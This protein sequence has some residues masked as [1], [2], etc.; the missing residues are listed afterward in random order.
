MPLTTHNAM[1]E[2]IV[3][4]N[5]PQP[6]VD[7]ERLYQALSSFAGRVAKDCSD[8]GVKEAAHNFQKALRDS[9]IR[10]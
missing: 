2:N 5:N 4:S 7:V 3:R 1:S 8:P 10:A 9:K 6:Q